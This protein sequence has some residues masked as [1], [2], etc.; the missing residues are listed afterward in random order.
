MSVHGDTH[1]LLGSEYALLRPEFCM[2]S[3][4][5][6][7]KDVER[8]L[9]TFGAG[10]STQLV[11][12]II[13]MLQQVKGSF[14][15]NVIDGPLSEGT[16]IDEGSCIHPVRI[17]RDPASMRDLMLDADFA[18]SGGGQTLFELCATGTPIVAVQ[19]AEN[20]AMNL[21]GFQEEGALWFAGSVEEER[22]PHNV[23]ELTQKL[24]DDYPSR[25]NMSHAGQRTVDGKGAIRVSSVLAELLS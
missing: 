13:L 8:I 22:T 24:I 6:V 25:L 15:L 18:I 4:K 2:A 7:G 16:K 23:V 3:S 5:N 19:V 20:Q 1:F 12:Q 21:R 14:S 11:D 10:N 9:L 17:I